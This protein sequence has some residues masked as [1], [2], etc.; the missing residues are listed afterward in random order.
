MGREG[1]I[2][3]RVVEVVFFH[4]KPRA[5]SNFSVEYYFDAVRKNL[6]ENINWRVEQA[7]YSSNGVIN[8]IKMT[9]RAA[10]K[11]GQVNHVTGDIHFINLLFEKKRS[12]LT[13]LDCGLMN[14]SSLFKRF[15]FKKIW[16]QLPVRNAQ[17]VT[18]ISQAT[19][20]ELL[21]YVGCDP[22]KIR[23]VPVFVSEAFK[24][25]NTVEFNAEKPTLLQIGTKSNK[26]ILR[27]FEAIQDI[28]C[29]LDIVGELTEEHK[30]ALKKYNIEYVNSVRISDEEI[31]KKYQA[32]DIVTFVSTYEGFGM[33][34]IEANSVNKPVITGNILSM[35]EVGADAACLV[36]PYSVEEINAG[37]KR[38]CSD[39]PY[40][41]NLIE[42][43][44]VNKLRYQAPA[45]AQ[46][47]VDI[48]KELESGERNGTSD[49]V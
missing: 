12:V 49:S 36:D 22:D 33:P 41:L 28:P 30:V 44:K 27:L 8:R 34:I 47:Y 46:L 45:I 14:T 39:E 19:K 7:K 48:Y 3:A 32:C 1:A 2:L 43:G 6:P 24:A 37:I 18:V 13:V 9:L 5:K 38:I 29:R 35:P 10:R 25:E 40:R 20:D 17:I 15:I 31:V 16:L 26:N 42:N 11:Q 21:K 4:R 23:V